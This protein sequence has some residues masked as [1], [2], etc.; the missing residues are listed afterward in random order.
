[1]GIGANY[2]LS[3]FHEGIMELGASSYIAGRYNIPESKMDCGV[4]FGGDAVGHTV[5]YSDL[6]ESELIIN[7]TFLWMITGGYN[8]CQGEKVNPFVGCG[9]GMNSYDCEKI[10]DDKGV[11]PILHPYAGVELLH[12]LRLT[13][14]A[15]ITRGGFSCAG[16]T[17]GLVIGGRPKK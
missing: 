6:G 17:L 11:A 9:L 4:M 5:T 2:P 8:F 10:F 14:F 13:G 12:H 1:M 16:V 3:K 15:S 7:R